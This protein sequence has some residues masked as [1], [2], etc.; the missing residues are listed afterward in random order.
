VSRTD[1][2]T[3]HRVRV[4]RRE[5]AVVPVHRCA[6]HDCDLPGVDPCW[7][8]GRIGLCHWE[9]TYTGTNVCSC[10]MCHWHS[11][12]DERRAAVRAELRALAREWNGGD[13]EAGFE[14]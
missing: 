10:W 8:I 12:P 1:A 4:A 11:R 3:P 9:F 13:G 2:H 14:L 6:G 7:T 5:V